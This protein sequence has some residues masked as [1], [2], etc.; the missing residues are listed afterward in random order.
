MS[1]PRDALAELLDAAGQARATADSIE[2]TGSD[3]VFATRYRVGTAG[4]AALGALGIAASRLWQLRTGRGQRVSVGLRAA[5]A[6]LRS[7]RYLRIDG[8]APPALADDELGGL[9]MDT[10]SPAGLVRHLRPVVR[11]SET[12]GG[13]SRPPVP[14]GYHPPVWPT[15]VGSTGGP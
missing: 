14:L 3:P 10:V 12:P 13:W 8:A 9:L 1:V 6:S 4:A 2:F 7:S 5:A 15:R 11:L